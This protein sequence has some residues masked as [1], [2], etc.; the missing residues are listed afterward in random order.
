MNLACMRPYKSVASWYTS[1]NLLG[2]RMPAFSLS[3]T[4]H[5]RDLHHLETLEI[6]SCLGPH[7]CQAYEERRMKDSLV[8][9][10]LLL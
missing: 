6:V 1:R 3:V 5:L 10:E 7:C 4:S 8:M 9:G 2:S